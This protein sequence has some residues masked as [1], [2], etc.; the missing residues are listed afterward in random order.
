MHANQETLYAILA[1][2][3][4]TVSQKLFIYKINESEYII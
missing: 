1:E 2:Y 4:S 3:E